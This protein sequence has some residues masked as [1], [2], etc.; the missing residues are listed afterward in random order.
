MSSEGTIETIVTKN[1][2]KD[3]SNI[4]QK[5]SIVETFSKISMKAKIAL[6]IY[7]FC[8]SAG[9]F[10][11]TYHD[12]RDS[13]VADRRKR[14]DKKKD[15]EADWKATKEGCKR[16]P[17]INFMDSLIFP[18]TCVSNIMPKIVLYFNQDTE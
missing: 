14:T 16:K 5:M 2:V 1:L 4:F 13:L 18:Y 12:G 10:L 3:G 11:Q 15:Y 8:V 6:G 7:A 9:F 17:F